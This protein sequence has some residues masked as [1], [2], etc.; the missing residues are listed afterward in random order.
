[1][2]GLASSKD[3]LAG[4]SDK[5]HSTCMVGLKGI[6]AA[7]EQQVRLP[8]AALVP[9]PPARLFGRTLS[10]RTLLAGRLRVLTP[11]H[12]CCQCTRAGARAGQAAQHQR[13]SHEAPRPSPPRRSSSQSCA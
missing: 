8:R 2:D 6:L 9:V 10:G 5:A 12:C 7:F 3:D 4:Q 13:L 11:R 1:M